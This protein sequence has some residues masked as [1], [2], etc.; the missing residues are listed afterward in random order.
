MMR[1]RQAGAKRSGTNKM[2]EGFEFSD[3]IQP[4]IL[5]YQTCE[6]V[7][8]RSNWPVTPKNQGQ[9]LRPARTAAT[10]AAAPD[11][12]VI[13]SIH[14]DGAFPCISRH[15]RAFPHFFLDSHFYFFIFS[16]KRSLSRSPCCWKAPFRMLVH[17]Q[18]D[19]QLYNSMDFTYNIHIK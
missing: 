1:N 3:R 11:S 6:A 16:N 2:A 10:P 13:E 7:K 14:C 12:V 17:N 15:F 19:L 8:S 5:C 18:R 9:N 4:C